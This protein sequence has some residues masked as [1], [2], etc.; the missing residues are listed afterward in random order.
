MESLFAVVEGNL[1]SLG[2]V[3]SSKHAQPENK[4]VFL[5]Q[6]SR[7]ERK[8][9]ASFPAHLGRFGSRQSIHTLKMERL[10]S[11]EWFIKWDTFP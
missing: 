1:L 4:E 8:K 7:K 3:P 2:D 6:R 10:G 5:E 11:Q 9:K